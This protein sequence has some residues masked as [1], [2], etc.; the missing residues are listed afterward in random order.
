MKGV[1]S[2]AS[3]EADKKKIKLKERVISILDDLDLSWN[4]TEMK[5][6]IR[7]YNEKI[8]LKEMAKELRPYDSILTGIDE[9]A[10]LIIH[11]GRRGLIKTERRIDFYEHR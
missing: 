7:M 1:L 6:A 3:V 9:V 10:L 4:K 2:L 8:C 5:K 11:L